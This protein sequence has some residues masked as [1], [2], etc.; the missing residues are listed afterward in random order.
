MFAVLM[1][2]RFMNRF[3]VIF[4]RKYNNSN[5]YIG[6]IFVMAFIPDD[7]AKEIM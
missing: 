5:K 7:M 2:I 3:D 4:D 6:Y 1:K